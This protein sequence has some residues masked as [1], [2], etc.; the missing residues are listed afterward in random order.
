MTINRLPWDSGFFGVSVGELSF[1]ELTSDIEDQINN[2]SNPDLLYLRY[3]G[4]DQNDL[5]KLCRTSNCWVN[6][7][8]FE[9]SL[10]KLIDAQPNDAIVETSV[11]SES[12]ASLAISAG[13]HSRFNLDCRLKTFFNSL[14]LEWIRNSL[15]GLIADK[16]FVYRKEGLDCGLITVSMKKSRCAIVGLLS[17]S[18][19]MQGKGIATAL[20][21]FAE[22]W[23]AM[24]G[25]DRMSIATQLSNES[26]VKFYNK[27]G[28]TVQNS[29][30]IF[31]LWKEDW[32]D[33]NS[34]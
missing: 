19:A 3:R 26:A 5:A 8:T 12:L 17:V 31:H 30:Y 9:R 24:N 23:A 18:P 13:K 25:A 34:I 21:Q 7:V 15:S 28:Y 32:N 22:K 6:Q 11:L 14:Y 16:V 1:L 4:F 2:P 10:V 29:E 33:E 20:L 27:A